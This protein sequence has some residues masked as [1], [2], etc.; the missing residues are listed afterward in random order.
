[1]SRRVDR[2]MERMHTTRFAQRDINTLSG[3]EQQR[4]HRAH[5]GPGGHT[6]DAGPDA[7]CCCWTSR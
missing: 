3:G 2:A 6:G 1:M 4:T 5:A 7:T